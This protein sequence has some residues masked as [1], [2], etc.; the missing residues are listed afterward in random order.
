MHLSQ[1]TGESLLVDTGVQMGRDYNIYGIYTEVCGMPYRSE[2]GIIQ[3]R[4]TSLSLLDLIDVRLN[5][6]SRWRRLDQLRITQD[7]FIPFS[8]FVTRKH[9]LWMAIHAL[10]QNS[11]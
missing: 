7:V 3:S 1:C 9:C 11:S 8:C 5:P 2:A 10:T 4:T 6:G